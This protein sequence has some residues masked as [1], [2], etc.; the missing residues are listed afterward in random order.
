MCH[1]DALS[2]APVGSTEEESVAEERLL[3][4]FS[5]VDESSEILLYQHTDED[6]QRKANILRKMEKQRTKSEK[7]EVK[8]YELNR[9]TNGTEKNYSS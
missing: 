8:D 6:L 7:G 4:V 5:I 1:V 9:G 2:R 3:G